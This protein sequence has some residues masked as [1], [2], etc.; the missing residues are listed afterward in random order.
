VPVTKSAAK[1]LRKD[2]RKTKINKKTRFEYRQAIKEFRKKPSQKGFKQ[3]SSCLDK[4]AKKGVIHKN[5]AAR[6]KSRLS[7]LLKPKK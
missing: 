4:A 7:K 1:A 2:R 6:L 3:T 5:K